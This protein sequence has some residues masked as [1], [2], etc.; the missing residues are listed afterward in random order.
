MAHYPRPGVEPALLRLQD[1]IALNVNIL[2][3]C[4]W[5][6]C[7]FDT[8]PELVIRKAIDVTAAWDQHV[9][10]NL[11]QARRHMKTIIVRTPDTEINELRTLV[12]KAELDAERI[13]QSILQRLA[14]GVL[15]PTTEMAAELIEARARRNLA[16]YAALARAG[17]KKEFATSLL[18]ELIDNIFDG[19][20]TLSETKGNGND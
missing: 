18:H 17:Q 19:D 1:D 5:C 16:A 10:G 2:L 11:R 4:C 13:E 20:A 8:A 7:H 6:G 14:I 15:N 9:T 3:W 12:K